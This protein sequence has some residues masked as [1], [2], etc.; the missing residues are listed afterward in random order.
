LIID[1]I[2]LSGAEL[3]FAAEAAKS[4]VTR[5]VFILVVLGKMGRFA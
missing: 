3:K 2:F 5:L 1:R 4:K